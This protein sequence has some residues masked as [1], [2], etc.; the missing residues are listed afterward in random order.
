MRALL[1]FVASVMTTSG[2]LLIADAGLTLAWQEP[3]SALIG[4]R[5]Q[6]ALEDELE[7]TQAL[8]AESQEDGKLT[9]RELEAAAGRAAELTATGEALGRIE[10]PTLDRDYVMVRGTDEATLRK[11]PGH[12][13]DTSFPGQGETMAVAGHRTT[14]LAPF[15]TID[16]LEPGDD[17]VLSM[18]YAELTYEVERQRIVP[19]TETSVTDDVGH[20]QLVLSACHP[21]YSAAE[22]LIVFARLTEVGPARRD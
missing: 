6:S 18:P 15:R 17:I 11:G 12:Y 14:Y 22:R 13:P 5:E 3:V 2:I 8:A 16:Q 10:L 4:W 1:R 19:P 7:A 20:E 9:D 21:L